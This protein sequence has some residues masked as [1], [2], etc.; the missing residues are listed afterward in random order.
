MG[1]HLRHIGQQR[2]CVDVLRPQV[3]AARECQQP[4]GDRRAAFGRVQHHSRVAQNALGILRPTL[5]QG[6]A[7]RHRL[8]HVVEVMGDAAGDLAERLHPL[9]VGGALLS[10]LARRHFFAHPLFQP[11][12]DLLLNIQQAPFGVDVQEDTQH[13]LDLPVLLAQWDSADP[14]PGF[15]AVA[16]AE[17]E[18]DPGQ[19]GFTQPERPSRSESPPASRGSRPRRE[20]STHRAVPP[21]RTE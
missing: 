19:R 12:V 8:Q 14:E 3:A 21:P 9:G 18:L 11:G 15:L 13:F 7:T 20:Q 4:A 10:G 5:D 17:Q 6:C 2:G 1:Q 16:I